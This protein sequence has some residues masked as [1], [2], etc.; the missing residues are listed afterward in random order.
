MSTFR[1]PYNACLSITLLPTQMASLLHVDDPYIYKVFFQL[2]FAACPVMVFTLARRYFSDRVA[3]LAVAYFIGFPTFFTDL[4][5][6]NRQEMALLFV[7]AAFLA[8][9]NP[10]WRKRRRQLVLVAAA[11]GAGLCHYSSS[12]VLFGTLAVAWLGQIIFAR[13]WP[14]AWTRS[15]P[16]DTPEGRWASATTRTVGLGCLAAILAVI[17]A[18][19]GLA[20]KTAD[21]VTSEFNS[22]VSTFLPARRWGQ[23]RKRQLRPLL[24]GRVEQPIAAQPER[25]QSHTSRPVPRR[26]PGRTGQGGSRHVHP[27]NGGGPLPDPD[28]A[29]AQPPRHPRRAHAVTRRRIA[30]HRERYGARL[31]AK[32][33]QVFLLIGMLGLLLSKRWRNKAGREYLPLRRRH[34]GPRRRDR[35]TRPLGRVWRSARLPTALIL[36]AAVVVIGSLALVQPLGRRWRPALAGGLGLPSSPP[37]PD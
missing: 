13:G 23:V 5:F 12:Y 26:D 33:E 29:P 18:W 16:L 9:T 14:P 36:V 8:M 19:G 24:R 4:P 25:Q 22:A 28:R 20:T 3:I 30:H 10:L 17:V 32:G 37:R 6:L 15:D 35:P 7:A 2:L 34:R 31:A 11:V 21:G 1:D 27:P